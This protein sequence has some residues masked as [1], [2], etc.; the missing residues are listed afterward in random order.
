M[1]ICHYSIDWAPEQT[2]INK[3]AGQSY[4]NINYINTNFAQQGW[5]CPACKRILA[6]FV[7]E[8]PCG[9]QGMETWTTTT[10]E[11]TGNKTI[12]MNYPEDFK[13]VDEQLSDIPHCYCNQAKHMEGDK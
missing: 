1:G 3:Q 9:G 11:G 12:I 4:S 5:Q 6:P 2:K 8:C 7:P 13:K 10:T